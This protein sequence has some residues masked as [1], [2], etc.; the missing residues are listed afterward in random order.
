MNHDLT[1]SGWT[2]EQFDSPNRAT[3]AHPTTEGRPQPP[4]TPAPTHAALAVIVTFLINPLF[5]AIAWY[6]SR[7]THQAHTRAQ[8]DLA[9]QHSRSAK[10]WALAGIA[11]TTLLITV[12]G[13]ALITLDLTGPEFAPK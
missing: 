3:H 13:I 5:G 6:H 11:T 12:T 1:A 2:H 8:F 7:H 4:D 9:E 10:A